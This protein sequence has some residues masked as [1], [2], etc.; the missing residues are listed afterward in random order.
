M[1]EAM[2]DLTAP[3]VAPPADLYERFLGWVRYPAGRA[4]PLSGVDV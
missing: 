1:H 4:L 3:G 2:A